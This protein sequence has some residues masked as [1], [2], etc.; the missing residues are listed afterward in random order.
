[1]VRHAGEMPRLVGWQVGRP[2]ARNVSWNGCGRAQEGWCPG[3]RA[4]MCWRFLP[5]QQI[6]H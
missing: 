3:N 5:R 4:G 6:E 1:M 2:E